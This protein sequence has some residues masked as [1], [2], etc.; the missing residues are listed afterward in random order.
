MLSD[1]AELKSISY[2]V[3]LWCIMHTFEK[4]HPHLDLVDK[5]KNSS[6]NDFYEWLYI[7]NFKK[8]DVNDISV[9]LSKIN[10]DLNLNKDL[11]LDA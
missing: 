7:F 2:S 4:C 6:V 11:S 8:C 10:F 3:T 1:N 5:F 9:F